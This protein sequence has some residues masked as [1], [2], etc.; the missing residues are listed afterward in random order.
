VSIGPGQPAVH[1]VHIPLIPVTPIPLY[2]ISP[3]VVT[4][5]DTG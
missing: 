3:S 1:P 2:G 4:S 5:D